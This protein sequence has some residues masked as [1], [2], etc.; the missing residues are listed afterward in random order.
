MTARQIL[1]AVGAAVL[2]ALLVWQLS[3]EAAAYPPE[4]QQRIEKADTQFICE[5]DEPRKV[6]T[7]V[8]LKRDED[9]LVRIFTKDSEYLEIWLNESVLWSPI[10]L[11][12][13]LATADKIYYYTDK[14]W[15][16]QNDLPEEESQRLYDRLR[17]TGSERS[18]FIECFKQKIGKM[19]QKE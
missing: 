12:F 4:I 6:S 14:Q 3:A 16:D 1:Y 19:K 5:R 7:I 8:Y 11:W 10:W 2:L 15:L 17:F 18:S 13:S 9:W